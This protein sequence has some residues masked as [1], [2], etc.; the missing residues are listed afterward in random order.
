[1]LGSVRVVAAVATSG[2]G[3]TSRC[4][5]MQFGVPSQMSDNHPD[6]DDRALADQQVAPVGKPRAGD[7]G[8]F[9]GGMA[10]LRRLVPERPDAIYGTRVLTGKACRLADGSMGQVAIHESDGEW[11]EVC[12]QA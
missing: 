8:R 5:V 4:D 12:V 6:Q 3:T 9:R 1:M 10:R 7:V 11:V 2:A